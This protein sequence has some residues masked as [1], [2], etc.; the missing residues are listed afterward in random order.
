MFKEILFLDAPESE[1]LSLTGGK[2]ANLA[3]LT[4]AGFPVPQGFVIT[5]SVFIRFL[6]ESGIYNLIK[7][8]LP[9]GFN[10]RDI[11]ILK[12]A[13][14]IIKDKI[15]LSDLPDKIKEEILKTYSKLGDNK[16]VPVA[17]R[18]SAT[19][20]DLPGASFAGQQD[21]YLGIR[22]GD[23]PL[24]AIKKCWASLFNER[25]ISYRAA[26]SIQHDAVS[27]AVVVQKLIDSDAAGVLFTANPIN[28]SREEMLVNSS[29]GLGEAVVS[30][31][32]NPD[33][34]V[35]KKGDTLK[36]IQSE[37]QSKEKMTM[38][39]ESGGSIEVKISADKRGTHSI[40]D[41]EL[42]QLGKFAIEIE[43]LFG[44]PQDIEW[45]AKDG[46]IH[47]LQSRPI[48]VLPEQKQKLSIYFGNK[49]VE[50]ASK[51]RLIL[52][53]NFNVRE[54]MPMPH[55]PLTWSFW[56]FTVVPM[57]AESAFHIPRNDPFFD[58]FY[59]L[60]K[61][62]G[63]VYW[64]MNVLITMLGSR[65]TRRFLQQIDPEAS[66]VVE[67]LLKTGELQP[68][69][70]KYSWRRKLIGSLRFIYHSFRLLKYASDKYAWNFLHAFREEM[71]KAKKMD[72]NS[73]PDDKI[74][75]LDSEFI[76]KSWNQ[77]D[78]YFVWISLGPLSFIFLYRYAK[79]W[80]GIDTS[81]LVAGLPGNMTTQ[82]AL[83]MWELSVVP[84]S[85]KQVF[86]NNNIDEIP[87]KLK[88]FEEGREWKERLKGFL[89][90]H[91]HRAAR[92]FDLYCPRWQEDPSFV[93]QM[94]KNYLAHESSSQ[95]PPEHFKEQMR[96]REA[97]AEEMIKRLS[98]KTFDR[99][100][101]VRRWIM[102]KA[103]NFACRYLPL[104]ESPK[105]FYLM[106]F[107][108]VRNIYLEIG[109]RL[110]ERGL[111]EKNDDV[112]FLS[113]LELEK[114]LSGRLGE[115]EKIRKMIQDRYEEWETYC[116]TSAPPFVRSDGVPV[117]VGSSMVGEGVF[118]GTPV[119]SGVVEG[120]ARIILDP[121]LS[122]EMTQGEIL[123]APVTDPGWTPLFLTAAGLVM[124]VGGAVSH[125]AIVAREYGIPAVVG[126]RDATSFIKTGEL[127]RVDGN[128]GRVYLI[129]GND[130]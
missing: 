47:I 84:E 130:N 117:K 86:L 108:I 53:S 15:L 41:D 74:I 95:S 82:T 80:A 71:E 54:T 112:F 107:A 21:T 19:A 96:E 104:R 119:S 81:K 115:R 52:W 48:T 7:A 27:I 129:K 12:G 14:Q 55:T 100:I 76:E 68:L 45:A 122:S 9:A 72:L 39:S 102:K 111:I 50:E 2:G 101:P 113:R 93:L 17:V 32:V 30:G 103:Y 13:S 91:G 78:L 31:R 36:I 38:I 26:N 90:L 77:I 65:I 18:S 73:L 4:R 64:N 123:V 10:P 5:T 6:E 33:Q 35:L 109:R 28:G 49:K 110:V 11:S 88:S 56:N 66:Q 106:S 61:V 8:Q 57:G 83:E 128:E 24:E 42:L 44:S 62:N 22:G 3:R 34:F 94:V 40:S 121:T 92:E 46:K 59:V 69:S 118:Q 89:D 58:Y 37:I 63:R 124:E 1:K 25:A 105:Y 99:L 75:R 23:S 125:G 87:R 97:C 114:A 67:E 79:K 70:I 16:D 98:S 20:E 120:K 43:E 60:D 127:I 51:G 29:F 85:V 126:V 116:R